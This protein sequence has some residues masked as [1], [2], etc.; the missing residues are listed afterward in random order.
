MNFS[1]ITDGVRDLCKDVVFKR[2]STDEITESRE[3]REFFLDVLF[4]VKHIG[5][6]QGAEHDGDVPEQL[7]ARQ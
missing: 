2:V 5:S 3:G 1:D 6:M 7:L 4:D